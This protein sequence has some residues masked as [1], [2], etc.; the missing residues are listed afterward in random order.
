M[1]AS[2]ITVSLWFMAVMLVGFGALAW[3]VGLQR[4]VIEQ[5]METGKEVEGLLESYENLVKQAE[6]NKRNAAQMA[7]LLK[8][9]EWRRSNSL[10]DFNE[11]VIWEM[12]EQLDID[13]EVASEVYDRI[14]HRGE[15]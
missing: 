7:L 13:R 3:V 12:A 5:Y 9:M 10:E 8:I 4:K 14:V 6:A 1:I 2:S 11:L 15:N